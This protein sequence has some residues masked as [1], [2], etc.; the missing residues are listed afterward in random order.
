[1][2]WFKYID[3]HKLLHTYY[4]KR[5]KWYKDFE[6]ECVN[7]QADIVRN[8]DIVN[9]MRRLTAYSFAFKFLM[10]PTFLNFIADRTEKITLIKKAEYIE[11]S[12]S[13]RKFGTYGM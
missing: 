7:V 3:L 12:P 4:C 10:D 6:N 8:L 11:K 13:F 9:F 2:P 5:K 1:M